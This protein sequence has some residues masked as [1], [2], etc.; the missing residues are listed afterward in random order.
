M[1]TQTIDCIRLQQRP[2]EGQTVGLYNVKHY[3]NNC[4]QR[5]FSSFANK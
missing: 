4:S 5:L 3:F 2:K 1:Y